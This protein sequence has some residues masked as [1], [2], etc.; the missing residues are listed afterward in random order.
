MTNE[1]K[2]TTDEKNLTN[3]AG[4]TSIAIPTRK[5]WSKPM[6]H[7]ISTDD[8]EAGGPLFGADGS[9]YGS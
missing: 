2:L 7:L 3:D 8:T 4:E 9:L 6:L 5:P 1:T